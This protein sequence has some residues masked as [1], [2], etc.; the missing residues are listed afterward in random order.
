MLANSF[1]EL[2]FGFAPHTLSGWSRTCSYLA[3]SVA[4]AHRFGTKK[5]K[6]GQKWPTMAN[7]DQKWSKMVKN[8]HK[9]A[10]MGTNGQNLVKDGPNCLGVW[11]GTVNVPRACGR[12]GLRSAT[13]RQNRRDLACA[14]SQGPC[15]MASH[16]L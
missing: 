10:Q 2:L 11:L 4:S 3:A 14:T 1:F 7:N 8:G 16:R 12:E 13:R 5:V 6:N 15:N 9:W